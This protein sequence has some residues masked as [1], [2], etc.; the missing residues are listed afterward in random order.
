M[1]KGLISGVQII[2]SLS[3]PSTLEALIPL[4]HSDSE[5]DSD[6][7]NQLLKDPK[8]GFIKL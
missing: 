8:Q 1:S 3:T 4:P 2:L 7:D 5:S 6:S